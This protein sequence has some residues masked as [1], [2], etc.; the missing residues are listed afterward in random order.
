VPPSPEGQDDFG[1][2][3][4]LS[5]ESSHG[6]HMGASP[7][8]QSQCSFGFDSMPLPAESPHSID[9]AASPSPTSQCSFGFD[10]M[11][12]P[13][14]QDD[15]GMDAPP[16][17]G[18]QDQGIKVVQLQWDGT[19]RTEAS[20]Q[21][22]AREFSVSSL[23]VQIEDSRGDFPQPTESEEPSAAQEEGLRINPLPHTE[24]EEPTSNPSAAR[25]ESHVH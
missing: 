22:E 12:L 18:V 21:A 15:F 19:L 16:S 24:A 4:D 7:S 25:G 9:M 23:P 11:P 5:A 17:P 13:E 20:L 3:A 8:S 14:F 10:S 2:D 1:M 6:F